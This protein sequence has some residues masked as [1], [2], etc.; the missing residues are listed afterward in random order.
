MIAIVAF[1][2]AGCQPTALSIPAR[3]ETVMLRLQSTGPTTALLR[4]LAAGYRQANP[5]TR[6]AFQQT[7]TRYSTLLDDISNAPEPRFGLT[8]YLDLNV[9]LWAAPIGIDQIALITHPDNPLASLSLPEVQAIFQGRMT[10]WRESG[11]QDMAIE[12]VSREPG[13]GTRLAFQSLALNGQEVTQQARL[14]PSSQAMLD[15]V[16]QNRGAIGYISL[17]EIDSSVHVVAL[18]GVLPTPGGPEQYPLR[19]PL[20]IIG[21]TAPV[22]PYLP[23]FAWVQGQQGQAI[24]AR[25]FTP[26]PPE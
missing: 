11:G 6:F 8:N 1:A 17:G 5:G 26:L 9:D 21:R 19:S 14:A 25:R 13:S 7:A 16:S 4:D 15:I 20:Y 2:L 3:T 24:V 18:E 12:V 22:A 10:R 23:F